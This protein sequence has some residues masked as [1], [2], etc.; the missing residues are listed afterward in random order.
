MK[1]DNQI[2][3]NKGGESDL[4]TTPYFLKSKHNKC[5][6]KNKKEILTKNFD[7]L[8]AVLGNFPIALT[9]F[10]SSS[11]EDESLS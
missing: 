8:S 9:S 5:L 10:L 7:E 2:N 6:L 4:N 1:S 3:L 11:P